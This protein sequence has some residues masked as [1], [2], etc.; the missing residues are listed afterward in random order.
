MDLCVHYISYG[1]LEN[2]AEG[3]PP[4]ET[5]YA[6]S[7]IT[8]GKTNNHGVRLEKMMIQVSWLDGERV[9]V[10]RIPLGYLQ[11]VYDHPVGEHDLRLERR[12]QAWRIVRD[13]LGA[14]FE[15]CE[16]VVAT[17]RDY[18]FLDGQARFLRW[19]GE[20]GLYTLREVV[21]DGSSDPETD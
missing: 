4:G 3:V 15:V 18:T 13:W 1:S 17:P 10:C 7:I 21:N 12:E 8:Q 5:V 19:D 9:H 20:A 11:Y 14:R 6:E 2:F 16:A